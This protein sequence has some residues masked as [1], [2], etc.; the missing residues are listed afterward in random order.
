VLAALCLL[1]L[2]A[3]IA[4]ERG[5]LLVGLAIVAGV[6]SLVAIVDATIKRRRAR[7]SPRAAR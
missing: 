4:T 5:A 3:G 6:L 7:R 1:T 2:V